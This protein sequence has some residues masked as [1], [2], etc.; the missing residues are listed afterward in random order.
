SVAGCG[1][2]ATQPPLDN[3]NPEDTASVAGSGNIEYH[4]SYLYYESTTKGDEFIRVGE[5]LKFSTGVTDA[6]NLMCPQDTDDTKALADIRSDPSKLTLSLKVTWTKFDE[7]TT[8]ATFPLKMAPGNPSIGLVA[9]SDEFSV[10]AKVKRFTV[11]VIADYT[12]ASK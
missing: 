12:K 1:N 7:S 6:I 9:S 3:I 2:D 5:K 8:D 4:G 10:P 11:E